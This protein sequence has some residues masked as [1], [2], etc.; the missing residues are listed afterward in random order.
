MQTD[1]LSGL[2]CNICQWYISSFNVVNLVWE[3]I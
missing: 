1:V 3:L 2:I